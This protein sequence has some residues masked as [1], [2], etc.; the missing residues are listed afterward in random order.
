[1]SDRVTTETTIAHYNYNRTYTRSIFR[2]VCQIPS[3]HKGRSYKVW[4][5]QVGMTSCGVL[6]CSSVV[7]VYSRRMHWCVV[8]NAE[9]FPQQ[10]PLWH[11]HHPLQLHS[12]DRTSLVWSHVF[13]NESLSLLRS[14]PS[15]PLRCRQ[16]PLTATMTATTTVRVNRW[17]STRASSC[18]CSLKFVWGWTSLRWRALTRPAQSLLYF[19]AAAAPCSV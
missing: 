11:L 14:E 10:P 1:M 3:L 18:I 8:R 6:S 9:K 17:R 12:Q 15:C 13:H 16:T 5:P 7:S 19:L 2:P 4:W